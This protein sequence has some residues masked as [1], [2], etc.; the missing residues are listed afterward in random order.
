MPQRKELVMLSKKL[1]AI[2]AVCAMA[3]TVTLTSIGAAANA[4]EPSATDTAATSSTQAQPDPVDSPSEAPSPDAPAAPDPVDSPSEAPSPDAPSAPDS[5]DES[6]A[7]I[8]ATPSL[9]P[10]APARAEGPDIAL[11]VSPT[12]A[13]I[14]L[15]DPLTYTYAVTNTGTADLTRIAVIDG[16]IGTPYGAWWCID[17]FYVLPPGQS[18]EC[19]TPS[20]TIAWPAPYFDP[21]GVMTDPVGAW[22]FLLSD[23]SV[24]VYRTT[25]IWV[26]LRPSTPTIGEDFTSSTLVNT[27]LPDLSV[28]GDAGTPN[29]DL[30][31]GLS[32]DRAICTVDYTAPANGKVNKHAGNEWVFDYTPDTDFI[33]SDV[34]NYSA[35]CG[36]A[37][38]TGTYT[39]TV[40]EPP[41][42]PEPGIA[43]TKAVSPTQLID[44]GEVEYTFTVANTGNTRLSDIHIDDPVLSANPIPCD[45]ASQLEPGDSPL[46]CTVKYQ[47]SAADLSSGSFTNTAVAVATSDDP[48]GGGYSETIRSDQ[49]YAT[50]DKVAVLNATI[51][52]AAAVNPALVQ[53]GK[54]AVFTYTI[55]NTGDVALTALEFTTFEFSGNGN[56]PAT[57]E[58]TCTK[59]GAWF[60]LAADTLAPD[61]VLVCSVT[62]KTVAKDAPGNVTSLAQVT[63]LVVAP[64]CQGPCTY[65]QSAT[66]SMAQAVLKVTSPVQPATTVITGGYVTNSHAPVAVLISLLVALAATGVLIRRRFRTA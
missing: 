63:S 25:T 7:P 18:V 31:D 38:I 46:K 40:S 10:I 43:L 45:V 55:K 16:Q 62:Y 37:W 24:S 5:A 20:L 9:Q 58:V 35:T 6:S 28:I 3:A 13:V 29:R 39:V 2:L 60:D 26:Y 17:E 51:D 32:M 34:I 15:G 22:A 52:L 64:T 42:D 53:A 14:Q 61:D 59:D 47:V 1:I 50:V 65:P 48:N 30:I 4:D 44:P 36:K 27:A 54:S 66:S 21:T 19:T 41:F 8:D 33:G 57:N 11:T 49:A 12:V 23:E 56:W